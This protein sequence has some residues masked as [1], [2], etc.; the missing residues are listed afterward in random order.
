MGLVRISGLPGSGARYYATKVADTEIAAGRRVGWLIGH[1]DD[2]GIVDLEV[3]GHVDEI[4]TA[5][6]LRTGTRPA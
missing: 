1:G 4:P 5:G 3:F 2:P 6:V